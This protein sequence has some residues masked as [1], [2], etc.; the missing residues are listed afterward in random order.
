MHM[1]QFIRPN[2][3]PTSAT[4]IPD[5]RF[6]NRRLVGRVLTRACGDEPVHT[7]G[8]LRA[9]SD[10]CAR[11]RPPANSRA[12][13]RAFDFPVSQLRS[14]KIPVLLP[15]LHYVGAKTQFPHRESQSSTGRLDGSRKGG[16]FQ[17]AGLCPPALDFAVPF[18]K[19]LR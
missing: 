3:V 12:L 16:T 17:S 18:H 8:N 13:F 10:V 2:L 14:R 6:Q 1:I 11:E 9:S 5:S 15:E 19:A 4:Q 7:F